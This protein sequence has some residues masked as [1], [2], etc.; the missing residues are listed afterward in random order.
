MTYDSHNPPSAPAT[1]TGTEPG[2][3]IS[4]KRF[5]VRLCIA[6]LAVTFVTM[7]GLLYYF[8]YQRPAPAS[9][10]IV[11]I[12]DGAY[13]GAVV[14]V[15]GSPSPAMTRRLDDGNRFVGRIPVAAGTYTIEIEHQG[16]MLVHEALTLSDNYMATVD[17]RLLRQRASPGPAPG[18]AP[19]ATPTSSR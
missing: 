11:V 19:G 8:W 14:R 6:L 4:P 9:S 16:R 3:L 17:L 18:A 1:T 7:V 12:G 13:D 5:F 2:P 15:E 10:M